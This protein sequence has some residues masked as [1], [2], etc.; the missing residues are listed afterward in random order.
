MSL[1][2]HHATSATSLWY[3]K[4]YRSDPQRLSLVSWYTKYV[5]K[6]IDISIDIES[7]DLKNEL[8]N[9]SEELEA[10]LKEQIKT[11]AHAAYAHIMAEAQSKLTSARPDYIKALSFDQ[12]GDDFIIS[13]E[14]NWPE[15][16]EEGFGAFDLRETLLTSTKTVKVGQRAGNP[17]VRTSKEGHRY[18]AVPYS[19]QPFSTAPGNDLAS[20]LRQL[21]AK[22]QEGSNQLLTRVFKDPMG[23]P[24]EGKVA[25][26]KKAGHPLLDGIVKYQKNYKNKKGKNTTQSLY[27]TYRMITENPEKVQNW[28]HPGY[29][30]LHAFDDAERFV[31]EEIAKII[32]DFTK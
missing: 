20:A 10:E 7:G 9:L 25:T 6:N 22:N 31:R 4:K 27:V 24:L 14:G 12:I 5:P 19:H 26:V 3:F 29:G 18:A 28:I 23:R 17:W 13:L 8:E 11:T 16:L 32:E 30:G 21:R 1:S 2:E 15:M